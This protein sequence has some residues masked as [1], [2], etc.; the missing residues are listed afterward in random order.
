MKKNLFNIAAI[1]IGA[2]MAA[3]ASASAA[4][5]LFDGGGDVYVGYTIGYGDSTNDDGSMWDGPRHTIDGGVH[6]SEVVSTYVSVS[7]QNGYDCRKC[8]GTANE[9]ELDSAMGGLMAHWKMN[10]VVTLNVGGGIGAYRVRTD[11]KR[12]NRR[13]D[14][15]SGKVSGFGVEGKVGLNFNLEKA[16][17]VPVSVEANLTAQRLGNGLVEDMGATGYIP[18]LK[19]T[20]TF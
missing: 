11:G 19:I 18:G 4:N 7:R 5:K 9:T 12:Q 2:A 1:A 3:M 14:D 13:F 8:S 20:G 15:G 17:R 6:L 10:D 16:L